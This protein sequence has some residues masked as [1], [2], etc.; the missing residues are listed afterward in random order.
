MGRIST[1]KKGGEGGSSAEG[2]NREG[3][4]GMRRAENVQ[5]CV[6][7]VCDS[8]GCGVERSAMPGGQVES[9][10]KATDGGTTSGQRRRSGTKQPPCSRTVGSHRAADADPTLPVADECI[11][12]REALAAASIARQ[13][14]S[15]WRSDTE[16]RA[17]RKSF[18]KDT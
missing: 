2:L 14:I 3:R 15:T 11:T 5:V 8:E 10:S 6:G 16:T 17:Q 7:C 1:G 18:T 9:E 13:R 12:A 4:A